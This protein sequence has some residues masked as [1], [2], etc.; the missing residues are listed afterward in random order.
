MTPSWLIIAFGAMCLLSVDV[1]SAR[2]KS[3]LRQPA[4]PG[5]SGRDWCPMACNI[6]GS[7][8][9]N[10][11]VYHN[12]EQLQCCDQ[13]LFYDSSLYDRVDP[14]TL[15]RLRVCT[16]MVPTGHP[17]QRPTTKVA[18]AVESLSLT[19]SLGWWGNGI[20]AST[21][22]SSISKQMRHYMKSQHV[23]SK[24]TKSTKSTKSNNF[25]FA[26]S[27]SAVVGIYVGKGLQS[28]GISSFAL[29]ATILLGAS[30]GIT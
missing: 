26:R 3:G 29:K 19:Y 30:G 6:A 13:T 2:G 25:L 23:A 7:N 9:S 8:L 10:S 1:V 28:E 4:S 27:G 21:D 24:S 11:S 20:L 5:Y 17:V 18:A 14:S 15:H 16:H 22:I 12:S